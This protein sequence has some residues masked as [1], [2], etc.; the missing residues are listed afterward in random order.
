MITHGLS[1]AMG[2]PG[3]REVLSPEGL[4]IT[5][6]LVKS[7]EVS[8]TTIGL[9]T[10]DRYRWSAEH[11]YL[12]KEAYWEKGKI[13]LKDMVSKM[14][15]KKPTDVIPWLSLDVQRQLLHH[16]QTNEGFLKR[17]RQSRLNIITSPKAGTRHTQGSISVAI[18]VK[19]MAQITFSQRKG[20]ETVTAAKLFSKTHTKPKDKTFA[21]DQSKATWA[22]GGWS[23]KGTVYGL[24]N[25]VSLFYEKPTNNATANKPSY[26]PYIVA[27]LQTELDST[28]TELNSTKNEIQQ[29]R[30]LREEQQR[31]MVEQQR[32]LEKQQRQLEEQRRMMKAQCKMMEDQKQALLGLQSQMALM[33]SL[34]GHPSDLHDSEKLVN[35][36]VFISEVLS[37]TTGIKIDKLMLLAGNC[38][39]P[40]IMNYDRGSV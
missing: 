28:K 20:G 12:I 13:C 33:S 30:T 8:K 35:D 1:N 37:I 4:T 38:G 29:Q 3:A 15:K 11:A 6:Y 10:H 2:N 19:K 7:L 39:L 32:Q 9:L 22:V 18:I 31:K 14:S 34:L 36:D 16:K 5:K 27:Q 21:D 40:N 26:T 17:S 25:S 24:G 23:E